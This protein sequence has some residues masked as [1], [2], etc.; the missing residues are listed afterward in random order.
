MAKVPGAGRISI[1]SKGGVFGQDGPG[2][3]WRF[4][5]SSNQLKCQVI[6][7]PEGS[8]AS[9]P[10][11]WARDNNSGLLYTSDATGALYSLDEER[12]FSAP[13]GRTLLAPAGPMAVTHDGRVF[14]FCGLEMA[15]MFSYNPRTHDVTNL[16]VAVSVLERRRYGYV[17][18]DAVTGRDG[19]IGDTAFIA[20][21]R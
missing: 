11:T 17:F 13:L 21:E 12:G 3:L 20:N 18:G 6:P 7:L 1:G 10:L 2:H 4:D 19:Q 5:V 16:G 15:K 8:W 9:T 14:G